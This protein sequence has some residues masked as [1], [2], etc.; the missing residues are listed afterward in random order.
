MGRR[1]G[2][3]SVCITAAIRRGKL[4]SCIQLLQ[5]W[6]REKIVE[7]SLIWVFMEEETWITHW[8]G[9]GPLWL[10]LSYKTGLNIMRAQELKPLIRNKQ[11][12]FNFSHWCF[13][14]SLSFFFFLESGLSLFQKT[15]FLIQPPN[16]KTIV[17]VSTSK[18][19]NMKI[20]LVPVIFCALC[21]STS[22]QGEEYSEER[23]A[24][25]Y[26]WKQPLF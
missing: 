14:F 19:V 17:S 22:I 25:Q 16:W 20:I 26:K 21:I 8:W 10:R 11:K 5:Y 3:T 24:I 15:F 4:Y 7:V 9:W 12:C 6:A 23:A 13:P 1:E 18:T 2:A